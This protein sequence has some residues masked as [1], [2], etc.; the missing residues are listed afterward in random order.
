MSIIFQPGSFFAARAPGFLPRTSSFKIAAGA[1]AAG[2]VLATVA[3]HAPDR[4]RATDTAVPSRAVSENSVASESTRAAA[5]T[6][7]AAASEKARPDKRRDTKS[8]PVVA[9]VEPASD[10]ARPEAVTIA[11]AA[12]AKPVEV[13]GNVG[14]AAR[15]PVP[16]PR[17]KP[18]ALVALAATA[19]PE[20]D[21]KAAAARAKPD[22]LA[23]L[24]TKLNAAETA[25]T[26]APET[27]ELSTSEAPAETP[28]E[29]RA[30]VAEA[31]PA[32][33]AKPNP[34]AK[35][36]AAKR[37]AAKRPARHE[38]LANRPLNLADAR[39]YAPSRSV[40]ASRNEADGFSLVRSRTLPDGRRVTVWQRPADDPSPPLFAFG[41]L[42]R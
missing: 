14:L 3:A 35:P 12:P 23:T 16:S 27:A 15:E 33:E 29:V 34:R 4:P 19:S 39:A 11:N 9:A 30:E 24:I 2:A 37:V 36:V 22:P 26:P 10:A 42:F 5:E 38:Y 8:K 40:V 1:F 25:G 7:T 32:A 41:S 21:A 13:D 31:Q 20:D 18:E 28:A 6:K 17:P